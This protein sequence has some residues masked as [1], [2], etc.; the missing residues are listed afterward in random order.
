MEQTT[1]RS[2][3]FTRAIRIVF[4]TVGVCGV[5]TILFFFLLYGDYWPGRA[6]YTNNGIVERLSCS[7]NRSHPEL[8]S[9]DKNWKLRAHIELKNGDITK[10]QQLWV[11]NQ[12]RDQT[13]YDSRDAYLVSPT[14]IVVDEKWGSELKGKTVGD[15]QIDSKSLTIYWD[16][17]GCWAKFWPWVQSKDG[18]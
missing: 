6:E 5:V 11:I 8:K 9:S 16:D 3:I 1:P 12:D 18:N 2:Q 14:K 4:G 15:I 17:Q 13:P 7:L 10:P